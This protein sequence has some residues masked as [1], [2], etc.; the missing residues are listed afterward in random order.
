VRVS[1]IIPALNE[2]E[3]IGATIDSAFAAGA[4]EVIVA[5][6]GS[7]DGTVEIATAH[8]ARVLTG[9][10][11]R[12]RQLNRGAEAATGEALIFLHAD[13]LLPIG[14]ADAVVAALT[15]GGFRVRFIE[16]TLGLLW[17]EF[18]INT[19]TRFSRCPWGDQAQFVRRNTFPGYREIPIMEDYELAARMK[20][21]GSSVL[22]PLAVRTSGRRFLEQGL[23]RTTALNWWIILNYRRGVD[24]EQLARWYRGS[25]TP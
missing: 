9:E 14:A 11:M 23:V 21:N 20:R 13:T 16:R 3:R 1:V 18:A 25:S 12:S 5:D 17:T 8:R 15:F 6:G 24:P 10:R 7:S 2:A 4:A 19:R 22:L